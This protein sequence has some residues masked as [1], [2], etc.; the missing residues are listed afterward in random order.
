MRLLCTHVKKNLHT[1]CNFEGL[2][3]RDRMLYRGKLYG[4]SCIY[5]YNTLL[6]K[7]WPI[8]LFLADNAIAKL[9]VTKIFVK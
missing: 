7:F 3:L 5:I 4:L 2:T 8:S 1:K 6:E 9:Y